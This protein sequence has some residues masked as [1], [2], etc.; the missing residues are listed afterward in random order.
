MNPAEMGTETRAVGKRVLVGFI[1]L[2]AAPIAGIASAASLTNPPGNGPGA[3]QVLAGV[4]V[5]ICI[6]FLA[7][8]VMQD[9]RTEP[10]RDI[11][12]GGVGGLMNLS[13]AAWGDR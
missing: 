9:L 2:V 7:A 8:L 13:Q 1:C 3:G 5:P 10:L 6:T 11:T 12:G 4:G